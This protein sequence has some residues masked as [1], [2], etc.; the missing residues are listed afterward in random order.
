MA[1]R[2]AVL[3]ILGEGRSRAG[4][5]GEATAALPE[6]V[7]DDIVDAAVEVGR[8]GL[9]EIREFRA[10]RVDRAGVGLDAAGDHLEHRGL[11]AA[12]P[13]EDGHALARIERELDVIEQSRAGVGNGEGA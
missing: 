7:S 12:V 4:V 2:V 5:C 6:P 8:D 13:S 10:V 9:R 1:W 3:W 11:A